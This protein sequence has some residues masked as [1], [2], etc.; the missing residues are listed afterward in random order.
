MVFGLVSTVFDLLTFGLPVHVCHAQRAEF[1][2]AWFLISWLPQL[3]AVMVLRTRGPARNS[4][5]GAMLAIST[6]IVSVLSLALPYLGRLSGW[7][8]LAPLSGQ[9]M[10]VASVIVTS[11]IG[12]TERGKHVFS[13]S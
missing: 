11:C 9:L 7:L 10:L 2:G 6:A 5:P 1:Q 8:A 3:A 13:R 4:T 12:V